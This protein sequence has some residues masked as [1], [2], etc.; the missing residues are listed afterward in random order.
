MKN[1]GDRSLLWRQSPTGPGPSRYRTFTI[2]LRHITLR[3]SSLEKC[4]AQRRDI[5]PTTHNTHT[6]D[7][8]DPRRDSNTQSSKLA[9]ADPRRPRGRR[10][11]G[12]VV[13]NLPGMVAEI[14]KS[15]QCSRFL[16]RDMNRTSLK[17]GPLG[18][19]ESL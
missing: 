1:T 5:Y 12:L 7:I 19:P 10:V 15:L 17:M 8:H 4:S 18:W 13:W 9:G 16:I 2:I 14:R 3:R 11:I 6:T